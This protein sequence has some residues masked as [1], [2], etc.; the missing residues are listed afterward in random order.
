VT[1]TPEH[2]LAPGQVW[3]DNDRR[4]PGRTVR[5]EEIVIAPW[6]GEPRDVVCAVLTGNG[7]K[8]VASYRTTTIAVRRLRPNGRGYRLVSCPGC[9]GCGS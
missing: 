7:G 4:S 3:A 1:T 2:D 6:S 5:V 8:P 9:A